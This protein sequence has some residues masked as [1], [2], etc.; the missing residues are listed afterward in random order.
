M[1]GLILAGGEGSRLAAGGVETPKPLVPV[2]GTPQVVRLIRTLAR[3]GSESITCMLREGIPPD[4][5]VREAAVSGAAL[6]VRPCRTPSS[7]H[8]LVEGLRIVEPGPVLCTMVDTVMPAAD[9]TR[10]HREIGSLLAGGADAVLV[11]TPYV[12]DE[13]PLYVTRDPRGRVL[14]V[15]GPP[16]VPALASGGVYGLGP[17]ARAAAGLA[18][19]SGV[20]RMRGFLR[21]LVERGTDVRAV[22]VRRI[23][24]LDRP[25]D[26]EAAEAWQEFCEGGGV[27]TD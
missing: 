14:A 1:H 23:I 5:I 7:L 6:R 3:L 4:P 8:T 13:R 27:G 9:W 11:L 26:L 22:E 18:L 12:H 16:G 2:G 17:R 20:E 19:A 24:D 15:G 25:E 21:T 10:V